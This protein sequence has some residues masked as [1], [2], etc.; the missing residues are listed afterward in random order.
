MQLGEPHA[1]GNG[2]GR[3]IERAGKFLVGLEHLGDAVHGD[4]VALGVLSLE[5][6]D[7]W[8]PWGD[9]TQRALRAQALRASC[10]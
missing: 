9:G 6:L 4:I 7:T 2:G 5:R 10:L 8:G 1:C 3:L